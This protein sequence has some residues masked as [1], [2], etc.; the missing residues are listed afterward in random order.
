MTKW[1]VGTWQVD[2]AI[3]IHHNFKHS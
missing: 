1:I 3:T 2:F